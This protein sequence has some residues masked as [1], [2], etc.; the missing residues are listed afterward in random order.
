MW[1]VA[2]ESVLGIRLQDGDTLR[3][4]P[5]ISADWPRCQIRYRLPDAKTCYQ[6]IIE[7]PDGK[8]SGVRAATL[9]GEPAAV[10]RQIA[11]IPL[12]QD[13]RA[14]TVIVTL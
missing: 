3:I 4:D 8:Q 1:R 11:R 12:V 2:V 6:I 9:D 7:N 14:H 13:G 5:R 10:D